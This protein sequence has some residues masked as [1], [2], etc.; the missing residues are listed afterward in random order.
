MSTRVSRLRATLS[1][2][3][4][5]V[6]GFYTTGWVRAKTA[7]ACLLLSSCPFPPN[8]PNNWRVPS[9]VRS[10]S[11]SGTNAWCPTG[12]WSP[13]DAV[14]FPCHSSLRRPIS[15]HLGC[16][17]VTGWQPQFFG[18]TEIDSSIWI[19]RSDLLLRHAEP[20]RQRRRRAVACRRGMLP[21]AAVRDITGKPLGNEQ[22]AGQRNG[23]QGSAAPK[24]RAR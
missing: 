10:T 14:S 17:L 11:F 4:P 2:P 21:F 22:V 3:P 23:Q 13:T 5:S 1:F 24:R 12:L 8:S 15:G 19:H 20:G 9:F 7:T 16:P 18:V 6:F